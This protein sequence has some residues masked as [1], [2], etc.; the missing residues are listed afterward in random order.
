MPHGPWAFVYSLTPNKKEFRGGETLILKPNTLNYWS[1]FVDEL[2]DNIEWVRE[3][4]GNP[5]W[6]AHVNLQVKIL[7]KRLGYES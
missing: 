3:R 6:P 1:N 4:D 2:E 7:K 5:D